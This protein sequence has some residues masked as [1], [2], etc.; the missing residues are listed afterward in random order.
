MCDQCLF[1]YENNVGSVKILLLLSANF[2]YIRLHDINYT[3]A[4]NKYYVCII[5]VG[6]LLVYPN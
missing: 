3:I 1:N 4:N 5:A 2:T 6:L